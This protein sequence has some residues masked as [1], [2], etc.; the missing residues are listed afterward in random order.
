[1]ALQNSP[2][3]I[4]ANDIRTELGESGAFSINSTTARA[5]AQKT[6]NASQIAYND[7]YGKSK[8]TAA[9]GGTITTTGG[10]RYHTFKTSG[11]F[12]VTKVGTNT[13]VEILLVGGGGGGAGKRGAGGGGGG[14]KYLLGS[15]SIASYTITIG[16]G[17]ARAPTSDIWGGSAASNGGSSTLYQG[18]TLIAVGGGGGGAGFFNYAG[19]DGYA[20]NGNGGGSGSSDGYSAAPGNG[21]GSGTRGGRGGYG[22]NVG[23]GGG[24]GAGVAGA[25]GGG[26]KGGNGSSTYSAWGAAT[27]TGQNVSSTYYYGGGGG[28]GVGYFG[29]GGVGGFGGGAQGGTQTLAGYDKYGNPYYSLNVQDAVASMGGGGGGAS[30]S[31]GWYGGNGG[32]GIVIIRYAYTP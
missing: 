8:N 30:D 20:D 19:R 24:G 14:V 29:L 22:S 1:M 21:N 13:A 23:G 9:T 5:L 12:S 15:M 31:A 10:F 26:G 7:F 11:T 28:G 27:S 18:S 16:N 4:S 17:G 3:A 25:D 2:L 32:S 6:T